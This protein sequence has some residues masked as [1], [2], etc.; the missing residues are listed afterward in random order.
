MIRPLLVLCALAA[1]T[2]A[3]PLGEVEAAQQAIYMRVS[4]AVAYLSSDRGIGSGFFVQRGVL[5]TAGHVVGTAPTIA[6]TLSNG[7]K[8]TGTVIERASGDIDLALV[9]VPATDLTP[10]ELSLAPPR[11]GTWIAS[12]GHGADSPWTF[13]TGMVS[14][15][16][17]NRQGDPVL[18][19]Q[20]PL[21]PGN[22]GGP[23]VDR[24][25]KVVAIVAKGVIAA[26][27]VNFAIGA[28]VAARQLRGLAS[29]GAR[30]VIRAPPGT[31]VFIDGQLAGS[32]PELAV[33]PGAHKVTA[34]V[35]GKLVERTVA[36][37]DR[38]LDLR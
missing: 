38:E 32:G 26:N 30:L 33:D 28:Q 11:V 1:P 7:K 22:S 35:R 27:N 31:A 12:V 24:T 29:L 10:L 23:I 2:A 5:L 19:T 3:D 36:P 6:V 37:T 14:N 17:T 4:P 15:V 9:R 21:N 20:I 16:Y 18:Q 34:V 13:T 25:G 8:L